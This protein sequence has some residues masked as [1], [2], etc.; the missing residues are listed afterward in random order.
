MSISTEEGGEAVKREHAIERLAKHLSYE[1]APKY[2]E[3]LNGLDG[4]IVHEFD[5]VSVD[6]GENPPSALAEALRTV[7]APLVT[8][9]CETSEINDRERAARDYLVGEMEK[10]ANIFGE[11]SREVEELGISSQGRE[12]ILENAANLILNGH[13]MTNV[14]ELTLLTSLKNAGIDVNGLWRNRAQYDSL[15]IEDRLK[16]VREQRAR[17]AEAIKSK[18]TTSN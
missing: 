12:R 13:L 16:T 10:D 11:L 14:S 7:N 8:Y 18:F 5:P 17:I 1:I 2:T 9:A 4:V 6:L 3:K 15:S